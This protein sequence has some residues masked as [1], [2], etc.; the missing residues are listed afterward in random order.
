M[1]VKRARMPNTP[2]PASNGYSP[3]L[4]PR[5]ERFTPAQ[6]QRELDAAEREFRLAYKRVLSLQWAYVKDHRT[7]FE[8]HAHVPRKFPPGIQARADAAFR[9]LVRRILAA[10]WR[11][12]GAELARGK[13]YVKQPRVQSFAVALAP[14]PSAEEQGF[15]V[16][17][18]PN[19]VWDYY[20]RYALKIKG[21][22]DETTL[23]E[24]KGIAQRAA[25]RGTT[26]RDEMK[27]LDELFEAMP[28][29]RLE[30]IARTEASRIY[31]GARYEHYK[32]DG[33]I[34]GYE[35]SA[36]LDQSLCPICAALHGSYLTA[37]EAETKWP[38]RH[39]SCRCVLLP[40]LAG[41]EVPEKVFPSGQEF[42]EGWGRP[43][44][45][46]VEGGARLP[47]VAPEVVIPERVAEPPAPPTGAEIRAQLDTIGLEQGESIR[48]LEAEQARI[49]REY[50]DLCDELSKIPML[51]A[52]PKTDPAVQETVARRSA[53]WDLIDKK[54]AELRE[55]NKHIS[56]V[57]TE[58]TTRARTS[59]SDALKPERPQPWN[60]RYG[61]ARWPTD[62]G[63]ESRR[64]LESIFSERGNINREA[65][66]NIGDPTQPRRPRAH[67]DPK[68]E[69]L[70]VRKNASVASHIHEW[71]HWIEH[72]DMVAQQAV[73]DFMTERTA[74]QAEVRLCKLRP[75]WGYGREELTK[76]DKFIDP[77]IGRVYPGRPGVT[78]VL[79]M[80]L[81]Y[82]YQD[83]ILLAQQDPEMFDLIVKIC[84]NRY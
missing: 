39:V 79:S 21:V 32:N 15:F 80:G 51:R 76:P 71:G 8:G 61:T 2:H 3:T 74:G 12:T 60:V 10:S 81:Q 18:L 73:E 53:Q 56:R 5:T 33:D 19:E 49:T 41:E 48:V 1:P 37:A 13:E 63:D 57:K 43:L 78:E 67:Y 38:P 82:L 64:F 29:Y 62:A 52:L 68:R 25:M 84:R 22:V 44:A 40:I 83:P 4:H 75:G 35:W 28:G 47:R 66:V 31:N 65:K 9:Q 34:T 70:M 42:P 45:R 17:P 58:F 23:D 14:E 72:H 46:A 6:V 59:M 54:D 11:F 24:V 36:V 26:I 55:V 27:Q 16:R 30:R 20:D 77:Y 50:G 69:M 7:A